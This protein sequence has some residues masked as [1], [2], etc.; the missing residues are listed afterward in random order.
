MSPPFRCPHLALPWAWP[1]LL[2]VSPGALQWAVGLTTL[3][4]TFGR[5]FLPHLLPSSGSQICG[6][7]GPPG[8]WG[9]TWRGSWREQAPRALDQRAQRVSDGQV[10][11][12]C[13]WQEP[14]G[15]GLRALRTQLEK[16]QAGRVQRE[17]HCRRDREL[18]G[19]VVTVGTGERRECSLGVRHRRCR[20]CSPQRRDPA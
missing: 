6:C 5:P 11:R 20:P 15:L 10:G 16:W 1:F 17:G 13:R 12:P 7:P 18:Q 9:S 3:G 8:A 14:T 2:A 4:V 19:G